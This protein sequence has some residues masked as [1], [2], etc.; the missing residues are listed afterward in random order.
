[1]RCRGEQRSP[2]GPCAVGKLHGSIWNCGVVQRSMPR[3]GIEP[4]ERASFAGWRASFCPPSAP[5][6]MQNGNCAKFVRWHRRGGF[7]IRPW[8]FAA[9]Q[10]SAGAQCAPL[11]NSNTPPILAHTMVQPC[12]GGI[13]RPAGIQKF[14]CDLLTRG[15]QRHARRVGPDVLGRRFP[16]GIGQ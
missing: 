8:A 7:H 10:G 15:H 11:Q 14:L 4:H 16:A 12:P 3:R 1:M 6:R 13:Q 2:A 9:T 5:L